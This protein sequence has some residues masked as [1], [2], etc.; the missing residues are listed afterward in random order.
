MSQESNNQYQDFLNWKELGIW[1]DV[2][3]TQKVLTASNPLCG[4]QISLHCIVSNAQI[5]IQSMNGE[6]CSV[7]SASAGILFHRKEKWDQ[8]KLNL[9]QGDIEDF[10]NDNHSLEG[11]NTD[12]IHFWMLMK[13]HPGRH[14]CALL[15][16]QALRKGFLKEGT[17]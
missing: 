1:G 6:S 9:Y 13:H 11:F 2:D 8:S 15:P 10:L 16:F 7:C 3:P 4:D 5:E 12:E 17:A 14:R